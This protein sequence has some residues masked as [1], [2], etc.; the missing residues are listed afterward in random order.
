MDTRFF[1]VKANPIF[2][3]YFIIIIIMIINILSVKALC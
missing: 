3:L 2:Q 1:K